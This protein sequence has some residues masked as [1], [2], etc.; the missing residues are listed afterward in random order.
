MFGTQLDTATKS[1]EALPCVPLGLRV[2]LWDFIC[3]VC[4]F[5]IAIHA[6]PRT[7]IAKY[8]P[9]EHEEVY[10]LFLPKWAWGGCSSERMQWLIPFPSVSLMGSE[11]SAA[12][13]RTPIQFLNLLI[14]S[15]IQ[16]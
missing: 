9:N 10:R 5:P 2:F 8:F 12:K 6:I 16:I 4:G 3:G 14:F 15:G 13:H 7:D 1:T 11:G